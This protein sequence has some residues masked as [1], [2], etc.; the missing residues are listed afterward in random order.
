[1][2]TQRPTSASIR[3]KSPVRLIAAIAVVLVVLGVSYAGIARATEAPSFCGSACHEMGPFHSAWSKGAHKDI[4]CVE[5]HVD[6][7]T[8]AGME[9]KVVALKEVATHFTGDPKFPMPQMTSVPSARCIRCHPDVKLTSPGFSHA[10][11]ANRGECYTCHTTVGH[12]VSV[13]ALKDAGVYSAS[14]K[15]AFDTTRTAVVDAGEANLAGHVSVPCSR[16][17]NMAASKCSECHKPKH[18]DSK[19]RGKDCSVCHAT[20]T[21]FVFLHPV[22]TDCGTCHTPKNPEHTWKGECTDC[23]KAGS[24]VSFAVTHPTNSDCESCHKRPAPHRSGPCA[25]CHT[26]PGVNWSYAHPKS[27]DCSTCHARPANHRSGS[28]EGCHTNAGVNWAFSHPG[29]ASTCSGCHN[30]PSGHRSGS[31]ATCHRAVGKSWS[32]SHPGNAS[33]CAECH[34]RPSGHKSGS[35]AACHLSVGKDWRFSHPG[36]VSDCAGCHSRPGGHNSDGCQSCHS[37]GSTWA[38]VHSSN[39]GCPACHNAPSGHYGSTCQNCHSPGTSWASA[40]FS[41][42]SIPGGEHSYQSFACTSCHPGSGRGPGH[43]CSCHGNT[44]GPSD[45]DEAV[46]SAQQ[47]VQQGQEHAQQQDERQ[48]EQ[49]EEQKKA[50]E[51]QNEEQKNALEQQKEQQ[52]RA[53]EQQKEQQKEAGG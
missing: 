11:H 37:V 43:Y 34:S 45:A 27:G 1:M 46:P 5:C 3:R 20:G 14:I 7:G 50:Q 35:C 31:C 15:L 23:H 49:N 39:V 28:C 29:S 26:N 4:A 36:N 9:H 17:H 30:R 24:G 2:N 8:I 21:A 13:K 19:D 53:L 18:K 47:Q 44:T 38:F 12:N 42:P 33:D 41:H 40:S 10:E 32:F 6:P 48:N 22:R 25:D 52:K 16:C 51:R